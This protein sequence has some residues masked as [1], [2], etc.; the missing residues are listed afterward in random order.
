M[1]RRKF[2]TTTASVGVAI[3]SITMLDTAKAAKPKIAFHTIIG[4]P[5]LQL[6]HKAKPKGQPVLYVHGA[7]FPSA[8][9]VGYHFADGLAWED[10]LHGAGFDVWALDFEG[11][12]GSADPQAYAKPASDRPIPL[13]S[14]DAAQQIARAVQHILKKTGHKK[15]SIIAHSWGGVPAARY[16]TDHVNLIEKLILFAPVVRRQPAPNLAG[17]GNNLP[18]PAKLP[19]WRNLTVA[20]QLARFVNDTP[21]GEASVLAEP[22]LEQWGRTWLATDPESGARTPPAV[23]VPGGPQA[24]I[25]AMWTGADLYDPALLKGDILFVRGAWDSVSSEADAKAFKARAV[26]ANVTLSTISRS[27]HLAHLETNR[28]QLWGEVNGFL[29]ASKT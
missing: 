7:T 13:R 21:K 23:R 17:L 16:A 12:G 11:F 8:L 6:R 26:G 4:T 1:D 24:D 9:S 15:L 25:I 10:A 27:G 28:A 3:G 5:A 20:E 19:A 18:D 14:L 22:T 2:L 29:K